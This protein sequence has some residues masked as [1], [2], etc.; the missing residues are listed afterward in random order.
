MPLCCSRLHGETRMFWSYAAELRADR[1]RG[2]Y[3]RFFE[4]NTRELREWTNDMRAPL[5]RARAYN[6]A[7]ECAALLRPQQE[8]A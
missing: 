4:E 8:S 6:L 2:V 3:G 5:V 1:R 7:E